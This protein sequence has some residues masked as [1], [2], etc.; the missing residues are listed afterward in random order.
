M[1]SDRLYEYSGLIN[2]VKVS[3][4][5]ISLQESEEG[6]LL[7][8]DTNR[9]HLARGE[10]IDATGTVTVEKEDPEGRE[11][12]LTF[13]LLTLDEFERSHRKGMLVGVPYFQ[14]EKEMGEYFVEVAES[15]Y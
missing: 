12:R 11:T 6:G 1:R 3:G 13:R 9:G 10:V 4:V 14:D 7:F 5:A 15:G 8:H 2:G